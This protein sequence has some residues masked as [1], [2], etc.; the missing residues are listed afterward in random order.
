MLTSA[1]N[2]T[3][4]QGRT[5]LML[6]A[7]TPGNLINVLVDDGTNPFLIDSQGRTCLHHAAAGGSP[8]VVSKLL[9]WG[10]DP[11]LPDV[12]GWTPLFWAAKAGSRKN[13]TLLVD[14]GAN[15]KIKL[16][17]GWNPHT[18][19]IF[20]G[21]HNMIPLLEMSDGSEA[22]SKVGVR[23]SP[24]RRQYA[25]PLKDIRTGVVQANLSAAVC[26][27]CELVSHPFSRPAMLELL[28]RISRIYTARATNAPSALI[29][30]SASNA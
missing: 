5:V 14:A 3:D 19:A 25:F 7:G 26:D 8:Q 27:S 20:H 21:K 12:D 16:Q 11:N 23:G 22:E 9:S 28:S 10:L 1:A 18:V 30:T 13:Y 6:A 24:D 29:S 2:E 17:N 4:Y 15:P